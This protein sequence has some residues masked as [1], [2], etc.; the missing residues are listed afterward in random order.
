MTTVSGG[1]L[2]VIAAGGTASG[3]VISS[4]G[5]QDVYGTASGTMIQSLGADRLFS[6]G[7]S[8]SATVSGGEQY[9]NSGGTASAT[10]LD[11]GLMTL[12][13]FR[14]IGRHGHR[15]GHERRQ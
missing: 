9:V 7:I 12:G 4:A 8:I 10:T 13:G 2:A 6:G 15:R 1:G 5:E 3:T 14:N 11:S